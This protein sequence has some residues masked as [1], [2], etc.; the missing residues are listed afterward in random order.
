[1]N[2]ISVL[3]QY[4]GICNDI[5]GKLTTKLNK[6]FKS[7]LM[8]T[9]V[10]Y[11]VIPGR[12]N[13]LQLGRYGESCEKR[14]RQNF[15]KDFDWLDF[16][17]SLA[18]RVLHG[19]RKAIAIDPS[20][21]SKSGKHTPWISYFWSGTASMAQRGLEILGVGLI[22]IDA[23]D[24]IS[25][26]AVQTPDSHTLESRDSNLLNWYLLVLKSMQ[27]KL[28]GAS[29][30]I[31]ADAYFSKNSFAIGIQAMEFELI[32]RFRNDAFFSIP[33]WRNLLVKEGDLNSMMGRL[34]WQILINLEFKRF[35]SIKESYTH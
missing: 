20:F 14:F 5:I 34:I 22:D 29:R 25:L 31:V 2:G 11:I 12:I 28:R 4:K 7:F 32:S 6:S 10:L 35:L 24:C 23:K 1:M 19:D 21:I 18:D 33:P 15:S 16:N 26:Q 3:N 27:N 8:E 17:L 13:F 9:L 30:Y